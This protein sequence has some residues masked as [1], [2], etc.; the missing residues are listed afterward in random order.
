MN[1]NNFISI[2]SRVPAAV[3]IVEGS[4]E[5]PE[6][7]GTV[8]FFEAKSGT[9]VVIEITGL[10]KMQNGFESPI[11]AFHIHIGNSCTG[12][13]SDPFADAKTHYNP[14]GVSHPYHSGDLPPLFSASGTAF[15]ATLTDRFTIPEIIGKTVV[16][17]S[18]PDDFT[19]Q[20]SGNS[21]T[22]IACGRILSTKRRYM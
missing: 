7:Y 6:I 1:K 4:N 3:A 22:K 15:S 14:K 10:P 8:R 21:G 12:N 19:T 18:S 9:L 2:F 13:A 5:Y 16:I 17:H 11:F 20:P